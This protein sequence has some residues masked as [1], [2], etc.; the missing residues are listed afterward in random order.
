MVSECMSGTRGSGV[1]SSTGDDI[2][3]CVVN[4]LLEFIFDSVYVDLQYDEIPLNFTAGSVCLYV[5]C[6]R[7]LSVCEVGLGILCRCGDCDV[8]MV[9]ECEC[10]G[11]AGECKP[12]G[13]YT[14][15]RYCV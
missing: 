10:D 9:R 5:V 15:F 7:P 12:C 3:M 14:W 2:F 1:L 11:N 4:K 6:S 13:W 8:C